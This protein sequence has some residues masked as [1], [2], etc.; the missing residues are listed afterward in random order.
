MRKKLILFILVINTVLVNA[1]INDPS[2]TS[3]VVVKVVQNGSILV[4]LTTNK[5]ILNLLIP[6]SSENQVVNISADVPLRLINDSL[7]NS[8]AYIEFRNPDRIEKYTINSILHVSRIKTDFLPKEYDIPP[9]FNIYIE[10][11]GNINSDDSTIRRLAY[12]ITNGSR[13]DFERIA[14]LAIWVHHNLRYDHSLGDVS[15]NS[16]W[17]LRNK[18]GTC[19]EFTTLFIALSRA[20]GIP[21]RFVSDY[22]YGNGKWERHA[23]AEVYLGKWIPVDPTCLRVGN[24]EA[25]HIKFGISNDNSMSNSLMVYG[26]DHG[27]TSW[28]DN[29]EIKIINYTLG[30]PI[31]Y[32]L[33]ISSEEFGRGDTAVVVLRLMPKEYGVL[34]VIL[35]DCKSDFKFITIDEPERYI[36]LKAGEERIE[37]WIINIS[38]DLE[39]NM[40]YYCPL[41]LSSRFLELKEINLIVNTKSLDDID[42][43]AELSS[44]VIDINSNIT[45]FIDIESGKDRSKKNKNGEGIIRL[46][47]IDGNYFNEFSIDLSKAKKK[48]L[49]ISFTPREVGRHNLL[50][51]TSTGDVLSLEYYVKE[52]GDLYM[53]DMEFPRIIRRNKKE[54]GILKIR[55]NRTTPQNLRIYLESEGYRVVKNVIVDNDNIS[56]ISIPLILNETGLTKIRIYVSGIDLDLSRIIETRVYDAPE[57]NVE[58][59]YNPYRRELNIDLNVNRDIARDI[60]IILDN[61]TLK[62]PELFGKK[63]INIKK[64]IQKN[65]FIIKYKDIANNQYSKEYEIGFREIGILERIIEEINKL[66]DYLLSLII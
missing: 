60:E 37:Y 45:V 33:F 44:S 27:D 12:S 57:L 35:N 66:I 20:I 19:D 17:I 13:S 55:N 4:P 11:T 59:V 26:S 16:T 3:E 30:K 2:L 1:E 24:L 29:I 5:M 36:I 54:Y 39:K 9:E 38:K 32:E 6:Q 48:H 47:I 31:D 22:A 25:T 23:Y 53:E 7:G 51:Y 8:I 18:R 34:K 15:M 58:A 43:N 42:I 28:N 56:I 40:F 10:P 49:R 65:K 21:A 64:E 62:I 14:R 46:G 52:K 50:I 41:L 63:R 61:K